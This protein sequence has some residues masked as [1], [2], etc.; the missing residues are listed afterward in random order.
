MYVQGV[1]VILSKRLERVGK[2]PP[3]RW[4]V[5][6]HPL[7]KKTRVIYCYI[8]V[9]RGRFKLPLPEF[10]T[11]HSCTSSENKHIKGLAACAIS[12]LIKPYSSLVCSGIKCHLNNADDPSVPRLNPTVC[13]DSDDWKRINF[14]NKTRQKD[15]WFIHTQ[16]GR[17]YS[18]SFR[19]QVSSSIIWSPMKYTR[20]LKYGAAVRSLMKAS[21]DA[22]STR[23]TFS[24]KVLTAMRT[25]PSEWLKNLIASV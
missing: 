2:A 24:V 20:L 18:A 7:K 14:M 11:K 1:R 21:M 17:T 23:Y 5:Y 4:R 9:G 3:Q 12:V 15:G 6:V 16:Y 10:G 19:T 22:S 25:I 13:F 8:K